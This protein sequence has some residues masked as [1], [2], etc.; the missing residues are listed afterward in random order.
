VGCSPDNLHNPST[1]MEALSEGSCNACVV[2]GCGV[3]EAACAQDSSCSALADCVASNAA[4]SGLDACYNSEPDG[5]S[6]FDALRR[7]V[8]VALCASCPSCVS[9]AED[10]GASAD[11]GGSGGGLGDQCVFAFDASS[12]PSSCDVCAANDCPAESAS[13]VP[14]TDCADY[15]ICIG[16]SATFDESQT[17]A[18]AHPTG[19]RASRALA[20]CAENSCGC[21]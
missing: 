15:L 13:C 6:T 16:A 1:F 12:A 10:G 21:P 19:A 3:E 8:D 2:Q 4:L 5:V 7:C 20:Q 14:G 18:L 17:C 11:D 9:F